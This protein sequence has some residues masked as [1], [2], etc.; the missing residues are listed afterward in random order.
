LSRAKA[1]L[2][3]DRE[4]SYEEGLGLAKTVFYPYIEIR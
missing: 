1:D 2:A 3:R 4:V